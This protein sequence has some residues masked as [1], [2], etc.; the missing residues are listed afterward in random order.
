MGRKN[1]NLKKRNC[2][3][4]QQISK[5]IDYPNEFTIQDLI[6]FCNKNNIPLHTP[7]R[8]A[9]GWSE[10]LCEHLGEIRIVDNNI[11]LFDVD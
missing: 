11:V 2:K 9:G 1:K 3:P 10:L 5:Y 7:I 6:D 4:T 8:I